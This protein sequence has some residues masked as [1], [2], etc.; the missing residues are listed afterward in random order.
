MPRTTGD[1]RA[2]IITGEFIKLIIAQYRPEIKAIAGQIHAV[3]G[4]G[5]KL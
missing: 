4:P 1:S 3:S 2:L 5:S